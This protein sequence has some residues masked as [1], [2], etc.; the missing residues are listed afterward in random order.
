MKSNLFIANNTYKVVLQQL[1]NH[2]DKWVFLF[3][4]IFLVVTINQLYIILNEEEIEKELV[5]DF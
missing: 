2:C 3:Y 1:S 4:K 5:N